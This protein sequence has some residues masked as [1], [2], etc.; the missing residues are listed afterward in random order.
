MYKRQAQVRAIADRREGLARLTG[1]VN[2]LKSRTDAAE[3]EI[4]RLA[5][6]AAEARDRAGLARKRFTDL[7]VQI[8]GLS[9]GESSLDADYEAAEAERGAAEAQLTELRH[10]EQRAAQERAALAARLD[11][12]KLGLD[13]KDASA[14]LLAASD[15]VGGVLGS[16]AALL[17]CLLYTSRCV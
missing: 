10:A 12:L 4:G 13:R 16:V 6:S 11:A 17:T 8:A 5:A 3:G 9:E 7:E 2:S 15:R 1:E 14:A